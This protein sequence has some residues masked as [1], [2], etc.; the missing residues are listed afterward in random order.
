MHLRHRHGRATADTGDA[1]QA[2]QLARGKTE[3]PHRKRRRN[4]SGFRRR[5]VFRIQERHEDRRRREAEH[6]DPEIGIAPTIEVDEMLQHR[7]PDRAGEIAAAD[8]DAHRQPAT[9]DEPVRDIGDQRGEEGRRAQETDQQPVREGEG[10]QRL[11]L[12]REQEPAAEADPAEQRRRHDPGPVG[13]A[14]HDDPAQPVAQRVQEIGQ[15][16]LGPRRAEFQRDRLQGDDGGVHA[17]PAHR[18]QDQ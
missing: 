13:P 2:L 4:R 18:Q 16:R 3:R 7:R 17:G 11:R 5:A 10:Q 12:C 6:P 1:E 14:A 8:D 15:R 9:P